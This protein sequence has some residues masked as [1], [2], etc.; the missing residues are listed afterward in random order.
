MTASSA[1][2]S[3][4]ITSTDRVLHAAVA[5]YL[6]RYRGQSRLHTGFDLKVFLSWCGAQGLDPPRAGR[7]DIVDKPA[8]PDAARIRV[9]E[10][11][12]SMAGRE[13]TKNSRCD[14]REDAYRFE[15]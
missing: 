14:R 12:A 5:A 9:V 8:S 11:R 13:R 4:A 3:S 15:S 10:P 1:P 7:A 6:G 2:T